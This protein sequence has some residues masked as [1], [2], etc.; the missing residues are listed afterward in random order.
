MADLTKETLEELRGLLA[1]VV[2]GGL[3]APTMTVWPWVRLQDW[4]G[5]HAP[6]DQPH[7]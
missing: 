5:E 6:E 7:D 4:C 3:Y 1:P 2:T